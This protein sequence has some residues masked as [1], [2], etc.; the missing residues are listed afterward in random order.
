MKYLLF[1]SWLLIITNPTLAQT[2]KA[3]KPVKAVTKELPTRY[4]MRDVLNSF[5]RLIPYMASE[6]KFRDPSNEPKI[7]ANLINLN[8]AFHYAHEN[9]KLNS[10]SFSPTLQVM[11]KHMSETTS[12]FLGRHK[13]FAYNRLK[14][15]VS[16]CISCHSHLPESHVMSIP[17]LMTRYDSHKF[18]NKYEYANFLLVLRKYKKALRYFEFDINDRLDKA[19]KMSSAFPKTSFIDPTLSSAL[20]K[21]LIINTKYFGNPNGA[22]SFLKRVSR[23]NGLPKILREQIGNWLRQIKV[24]GSEKWSKNRVNPFIPD[25]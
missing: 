12:S 23:H 22:T 6:F 15:T 5:N 13:I 18:K 17:S 3:V 19:S 2:K 24:L 20:K 21:I 14:S 11:Q 8:Q 4:I 7:M 9:K 10:P 1:L 16:L 25:N